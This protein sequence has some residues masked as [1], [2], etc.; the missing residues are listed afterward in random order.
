MVAG[1]E[2]G[3]AGWP[4]P[5]RADLLTMDAMGLGQV[6]DLPLGQCSLAIQQRTEI[7]R[8]V[9]RDARVF[10]FDEPNSAL[11]DA[12]SDELF[13][14]MRKLADS[15]RIVLLITHRL[16]DLVRHCARVAVV[17]D[18]R[19]RAILSGEALTE[20]GLA[21]QMVTESAGARRTRLVGSPRRRVGSGAGVLG[22]RIGRARRPLPTSIFPPTLAKSSR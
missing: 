8:A 14:E 1:R 10:L 4:K 3:G 9:A 11:T 18:G 22:S 6:R 20:E 16:S 2:S 13:H 21:R 17:R 5:S 19:V 12:E 7:A 15:G